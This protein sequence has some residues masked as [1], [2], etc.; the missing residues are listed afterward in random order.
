MI[1]GVVIG[2]L[3]VAVGISGL[4]GAAVI[5]KRHRYIHTLSL[6]S[7]LC[8]Y[9]TMLSTICYRPAEAKGD[10]AT[11]ANPAYSMSGPHGKLAE[12]EGEYEIPQYTQPPSGAE[13]VYEGVY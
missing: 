8:A 5:V 6:V 12:T 1:V 10:M 3:G 13:G 2:L 4:I 9:S 7:V 11:E